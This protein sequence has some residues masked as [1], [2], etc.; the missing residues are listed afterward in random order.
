MYIIYIYIYTYTSN[1]NNNN[2]NNNNEYI[3]I[4]IYMSSQCSCESGS[5]RAHSLWRLAECGWE[6]SSR[7]LGSKRAYHRPRS[8][9]MCVKHGGVR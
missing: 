7:S 3:Y 1:N 2:N 5:S 8:I 9:G 4:Y 6:T